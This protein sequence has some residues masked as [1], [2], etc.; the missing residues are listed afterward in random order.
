MVEAA[1]VELITVLTRRKL[2][3]LG[4]ATTAKKPFIPRSLVRSLYE[5]RFE[6]LVRRRRS[7]AEYHPVLPY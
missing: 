1:G 5:N 4:I 2:L 6:L 7:Q 3:I